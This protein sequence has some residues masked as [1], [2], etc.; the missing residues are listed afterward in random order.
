MIQNHVIL[1]FKIQLLNCRS[2]GFVNLLLYQKLIVARTYPKCCIY[3]FRLLLAVLL[4]ATCL[5]C[6]FSKAIY[7]WEVGRY[8]C[9]YVRI[10]WYG[11]YCLLISLFLFDGQTFVFIIFR[12]SRFRSI[13]VHFPLTHVVEPSPL[14]I[15]LSLLCFH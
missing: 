7:W 14:M 15:F 9:F 3:F 6:F 13:Q 1:V 5:C 8:F 11:F 12:C 10:L 4:N 2:S